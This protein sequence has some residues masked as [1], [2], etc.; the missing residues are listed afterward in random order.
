[1]WWPPFPFLISPLKWRYIATFQQRTKERNEVLWHIKR[2]WK[3]KVR[4]WWWSPEEEKVLGSHTGCVFFSSCVCVC[5]TPSAIC[6]AQSQSS[7]VLVVL[8]VFVSFAP[9]QWWWWWVVILCVCHDW[10][11]SSLSLYYST[12]LSGSDFGSRQVIYCCRLYSLPLLL[13]QQQQQHQRPGIS[14]VSDI[15]VLRVYFCSDGRSIGGA[16]TIFTT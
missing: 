5:V 12:L 14:Q 6:C 8:V 10:A 3:K 15:V 9:G 1:M 7:D 2:K 13:L 11:P 4:L 16:A